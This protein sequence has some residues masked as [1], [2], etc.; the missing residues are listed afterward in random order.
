MRE[1]GQSQIMDF[2]S[3]G[4]VREWWVCWLRELYASLRQGG[5]ETRKESDL[6]RRVSAI[7]TAVGVVIPDSTNRGAAVLL[8]S[9]N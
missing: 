9:L 7:L 3:L 4:L 6:P 1:T 5:R 8:R 2:P